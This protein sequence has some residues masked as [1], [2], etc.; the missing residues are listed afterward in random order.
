MATCRAFVY[1]G[2]EDF[3]IAPV[4]AMAS[5][6]PVIGLGKG[7]LLDT[8]RCISKTASSPTGLLFS[9][10][11][12][13]SIKS[14]VEWF[15]SQKLWKHSFDAESLHAWASNFRTESFKIKF[16]DIIEKAWADYKKTSEFAKTDPQ[17]AFDF[18]S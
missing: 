5:G 2:I 8:V 17:E 16:Q 9:D 6:A 1:A 18:P 12:V 4:E 11:T 10:Q 14:A 3:G 15:E 7:G 13:D